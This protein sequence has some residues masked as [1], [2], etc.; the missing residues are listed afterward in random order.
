MNAEHSPVPVA[1]SIVILGG[2]YAGMMASNRLWASL[3][4]AERE[5]VHV[6]IV[7][8]TDN[9]VHRI[10]LHE[11]AAGLAD[12]RLTLRSMIHDDVEVIVG[13]AERIDSAARVVEIRTS[14]GL[15]LLDYHYLVYAVGSRS[16][17]ITPG[18]DRFALTIGDSQGADEI[19]RR[20]ARARE[21]SLCVVGGGPTGIET[22]AELAEAHPRFEV[23]LLAGNAFA[24]GLR[25]AARRSIRRVLERMGVRIVEGSRVQRVTQLGVVLENGEQHRYDLVVWA[26]GFEVPD[27]AARSGLE[28]DAC[29]RLTVDETLVSVTDSRIVGAGDSV[30]VPISVGAHLPMGARVALPMGGAAADTLLAKL[31]GQR[32]PR[33]SLGL[34]GPSISL[35]RRRGYIQLAHRDD[36][37]TPIAFT[38]PL[39][40]A[41]KAWVCQMSVDTPREERSRPGAYR[42]P[43]GPRESLH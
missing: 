28:T 39:G 14:S 12:A 27:L 32:A 42:V 20:T 3:T 1:K 7:N 17:T 5:R 35:G 24:A 37:P 13:Q 23:T 25:P 15:R 40:A 4:P 11:H 6:T 21:M 31:R 43:R 19:R 2:G 10:R 30:R 18:V 34:L 8:P 33:L 26:A 29:G 36:T 16:A 22:V 9:F 38:G 41:I